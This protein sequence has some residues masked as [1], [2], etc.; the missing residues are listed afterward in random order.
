VDITLLERARARL[1]RETAHV[2]PN[3]GAQL[4]IALAY[5]NTYGVGM[6]NLGIHTLYRLLNG[7][8]G[9]RCERVF[10]PDGDDLDRHRRT[11]TPLFALESQQPVNGFDLL[12]F[13][14]SFE[15]DYPHLLTMLDLAGMPRRA[16]A[17]TAHD[18]LVLMGGAAVSINPEPVAPFIDVCCVGEGEDLVQPLVDACFTATSRQDLLERLAPSPGFYVPALYVPE[19]APMVD[20]PCERF[21]GLAASAPAPA[22]VTKVRASLEGVER[23]AVTAIQTPDTEFGDRIIAEVARGCTKGCRYC[24]VGYSILPFR[25]HQVEDVL[26]AALPWREQTD[27]IGLVAT[28]LLDHPQIE[29]IALGLRAAGF[30]VFSPSL[31]I[32]TLRASLLETVVASGQQT[33]TI[34][35][36]A[37]SDRMREVVMKKITNDEILDKVR[38]IFRAGAVNLKNYIIVGLPGET[39][40]D[41]DAIVEL[42]SQMREIMIEEGRD[43]GRI[44]TITMSINCLIPKPGTPFQ[45]AAQLTAKEYRRRLR[46]LRKQI[47]KIPNLVLDA[48]PPRVAEIQAVTSRGD[49]RVADLLELWVDCGDFGEAMRSWEEAGGL[50]LQEFLRERDPFEP[51]PWGHLR[52]GP[53]TPA[54]ANQWDRA[55]AVAY[56]PTSQGVGA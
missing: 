51:A 25:V 42:G 48:M 53:G 30:K 46:R 4:R 28:A 8:A 23:V 38:M 44:G 49:R 2:R 15:N 39:D 24:W 7:L 32:S 41:L 36:E 13:S 14:T 21:A 6:S 40:E 47:A 35:P 50:P 33:I 26:A 27:R 54:L 31:I 56:P 19:Y 10:L 37:G 1:A 43:R 16:S 55:S 11:G 20:A 52:V 34:A 45:W 12:A 3:S 22:I 18:P 29:E 9:V 5:P 17:R